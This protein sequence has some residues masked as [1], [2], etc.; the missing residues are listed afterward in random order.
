MAGQ[1]PVG[2]AAQLSWSLRRYG[3]AAAWIDQQKRYGFQGVTLFDALSRAGFR[4]EHALEEKRLKTISWNR[5]KDLLNWLV[6][7]EKELKGNHSQ[8]DLAR[9]AL[10]KFIFRFR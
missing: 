1:T 5:A 4:F 10:E 7:L 6:E 3:V 8:E 9:L 2:I